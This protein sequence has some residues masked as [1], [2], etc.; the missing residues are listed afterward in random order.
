MHRSKGGEAY[1]ISSSW[2]REEGHFHLREKKQ[3]YYEEKGE[4]IKKIPETLSY[5][6]GGGRGGMLQPMARRGKRSLLTG[7]KET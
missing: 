6:P 1:S 7:G 5:E 3:N 4:E 2:R